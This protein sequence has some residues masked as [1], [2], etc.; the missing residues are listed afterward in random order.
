MHKIGEKKLGVLKA[1]QRNI[2]NLRW[3]CRDVMPQSQI[4]FMFHSQLLYC[5][6]AAEIYSTND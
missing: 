1:F 4:A 2:Y 5:Q 3:I 6:E